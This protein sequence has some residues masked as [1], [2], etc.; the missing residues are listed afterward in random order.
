[1]VATLFATETATG[2]EMSARPAGTYGDNVPLETNVGSF[3]LFSC[4]AGPGR[5]LTKGL[6]KHGLPS[7]SYQAYVDFQPGPT[8]RHRYFSVF[9]AP[10]FFPP[11]DRSLT[12]LLFLK[13]E[14]VLYVTSLLLDFSRAALPLY[15][16]FCAPEFSR[17]FASKRERERV[18]G[19]EPNQF[20]S[21]SSSQFPF[22][23]STSR[24]GGRHVSP[25]HMH[26]VFGS[27][28]KAFPISPF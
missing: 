6:R 21:F 19:V 20:L 10:L 28:K 15:L 9:F 8:S 25:I 24:G 22:P 1:L 11:H 26:V 23:F 7:F 14:F 5:L 18:S 2:L 13:P 12:G 17:V 27:G 3:S 4:L 16:Q